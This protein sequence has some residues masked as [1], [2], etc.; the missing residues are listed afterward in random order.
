MIIT[1]IL[2]VILSVNGY[3]MLPVIAFFSVLMLALAITYYLQ[4]RTHSNS[5]YYSL[6]IRKK[7]LG[8]IIAFEAGCC[9]L[10]AFIAGI[11]IGEAGL[12]F[13]KK[14]S[15]YGVKGFS[16]GMAGKTFG[17]FAAVVLISFLIN[18]HLFEHRSLLKPTMKLQR[19]ERIPEYFSVVSVIIG[20]IIS[21]IA[22]VK[23]RNIYQGE[24][25]QLKVQMLAG[26]LVLFYGLAAMMLRFVLKRMENHEEKLLFV[27]PWRH[28]FI[29]NYCFW[30]LMFAFLTLAGMTYL[31]ELAAME[32]SNNMEGLYPYEFACMS[33]EEDEPYFQELQEKY[34]VQIKSVPMMRIT[35]P[36]GEK[37]SWEQTFAGAFI[38][39]LWPQGQHIGISESSYYALGKYLD[40]ESVPQLDLKG[41]EVHIV[42]QQDCSVK[43]HPLDW[44][45]GIKA[46]PNGRTTMFKA[47]YP[48]Q[49]APYAVRETIFPKYRVKSSERKILTGMLD[50]G[51]QE[52]I[53]VFSDKYFE[54][55]ISEEGPHVLKLV[56][57]EE[58]DYDSI[59][60]SLK[61]YTQKHSADSKWDSR[62]QPYYGKKE[63]VARIRSAH[64]TRKVS[65]ILIIGVLLLT[66]F[67]VFYLK[68]E[69]EREKTVSKIS[70]LNG[71]GMSV[72]E[73]KKLLQKEMCTLTWGSYLASVIPALIFVISIEKLRMFTTIEEAVF[74]KNWCLFFL[75]YTIIYAGGTF[76]LQ[77]Y[78]VRRVLGKN[79]YRKGGIRR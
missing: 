74:F 38:K 21:G 26:C 75:I 19:D 78:H 66:I 12:Y 64:M 76:I 41:E 70:I 35:T 29:T 56:N 72:K 65:Y 11:L 34:K 31:P 2:Y 32:S 33:Y 45:M 68:Y 20:L 39:T 14:I 62:I 69:M 28:R 71:L 3:E 50:E 30:Y 24:S 53:V 40:E 17:V 10:G 9:L 77:K 22:I 67:F 4:I 37:Y 42:F 6:G 7:T 73:Q 57:C 16:F 43:A 27:L 13:L 63:V 25:I 60:A 23:Y 58:T 54:K 61:A 36:L 49:Y 52:N 15:D 59:A 44:Y 79:A 18:Y 51:K 46:K 48:V 47:G 8:I 5:V 1:V 55:S